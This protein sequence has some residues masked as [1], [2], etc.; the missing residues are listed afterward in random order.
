MLAT[1]SQGKVRWHQ[2][3]TRMS[4]VRA[5]SLM[6][7]L[8]GDCVLI[9]LALWTAV[10]IASGGSRM[11]TDG[12]QFWLL[13]AVALGVKIPLL[14]G[15]GLYTMSW[16]YVSTR[17]IAGLIR[18]VTVSSATLV[19]GATAASFLLASQ[20]TLTSTPLITI[21]V[22]DYLLTLVLLGGFRSAKR[23]TREWLHHRDHDSQRRVLIAGAGAAGEQVARRLR[24][25]DSAK[26]RAVGFVDDALS[27]QGTALHG[28]PVL[29]TREA[30]PELVN[31]M[32]VDELW[33][34][35]PSCP[36][37]VIR[38]VVELGRQGGLEH[39]KVVPGL[40]T[41]ISGQV[42]LA[43]IRQVQL[44]DLLARE[45]VRIDTMQ[46]TASLEDKLVLVTGAS[47]SI[48]AVLCRKISQFNP[49]GLVLLDQ[50]ESGLFDIQNQLTFQFPHLK[51]YGVLGDV[52]DH[53]KV[54]RVFQ[55]FRP[56]VVFHAAAYKHVPL[57]ET[58]PE[59]A[60]KT[61]VM[62]TLVVGKAAVRWR[63]EQFVLIS[64][65][66]AVNPTSIM[67]AS[68]RAAEVVIHELNR[69]RVTRF[70]TVRFGN[71]LGSRG[72][73]VPTFQEQIARGGPVTVTHPEMK[74]YFMTIDEAVMLVLQAAAIGED[75]NVMVLDMGEPILIV[76]L[77]RHLIRLS[78]F[79]PDRDIP[80]VF[81]GSRPGEKLFED[82]LTAEEGTTSTCHERVFVAK[83][84]G[85]IQGPAL[86]TSLKR[87][88][89][90]LMRNSAEQM[91]VALRTIVPTYQPDAKAEILLNVLSNGEQDQSIGSLNFAGSQ[92]APSV[93]HPVTE[94][95]N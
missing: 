67:G 18:A 42:R 38:E 3:M 36:G 92:Q 39:I 35:M 52:C 16:S 40:G 65:D 8:A 75:G 76:E 77:A 20:L 45:Q 89:R 66:K 78:G 46:V 2:A 81:T 80:I 47:G 93:Y 59:D 73:V 50:D 56:D 87:L 6:L 25:E 95:S 4:H 94:S 14:Q 69:S 19:I 72:S 82:L 21:V 62:G 86:E 54:D 27:K 64:T 10:A 31:R 33:I 83:M 22:I 61:N 13:V 48:G 15:C 11:E 44:E 55:K 85:I 34:A 91:I 37:S 41:L 7:F 23:L 90:A 79:E 53:A 9:T 12:S 51:T 88:D 26:H 57:M 17:E 68:K 1:L 70:V 49:K 5:N 28:V 58:Q 43:D 74:R 84:N 30:I 29:G 60:I 24:E 63:S 32:G 71:V